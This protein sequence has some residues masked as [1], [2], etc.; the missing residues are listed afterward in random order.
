MWV[1]ITAAGADALDAIGTRARNEMLQDDKRDINLGKV[2][3]VRACNA[4][5]D[6]GGTWNTMV[7]SGLLLSHLAG[8]WHRHTAG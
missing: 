7:I 4:L 2:G 8:R 3:S 5:A 1:P 6:S